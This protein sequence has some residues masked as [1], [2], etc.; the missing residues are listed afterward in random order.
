MAIRGIDFNFGG[1]PADTLL[2]DLHPDLRAD[3]VMAN[4]PFNMKVWWNEKLGTDPRWIAGHATPGQRQLR[5]GATH[6]LASGPHRQHGAAA[7]QRFDEAPPNTNNQGEIRKRLVENDY[8]GC[9]GAPP[10]Q[11]FTNTQIPACMTGFSPATSRTPAR[12]TRRSATCAASSCSS[13]PASWAT[14]KDCVLRHFT[15]ER[16]L[17]SC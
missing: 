9:K 13:T 1:G 8:V 15:Q 6:A 11:L 4:P 7:G 17:E 16:H 3:F 5:P 2:N 10:G 14:M 12:W